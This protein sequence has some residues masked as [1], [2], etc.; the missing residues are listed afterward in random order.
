MKKQIWVLLC[1]GMLATAMLGGCNKG[2]ENVDSADGALEVESLENVQGK[3]PTGDVWSVDPD[4]RLS[5]VDPEALMALGRPLA[6]GE[7]EKMETMGDLM[8]YWAD[9]SPED[10]VLTA[11]YWADPAARKITLEHIYPVF[12]KVGE[13]LEKN[14]DSVTLSSVLSDGYVTRLS[15]AY[16]EGTVFPE[17][18]GLRFTNPGDASSPAPGLSVGTE[19]LYAEGEG[20]TDIL[21]RS[22]LPV[23]QIANHS[24]LPF[25]FDVDLALD[26]CMVETKTADLPPVDNT[27]TGFAPVQIQLSPLSLAITYAVIGPIP[28][29]QELR[30]VRLM[31]EGEV[32]FT[33]DGNPNFPGEGGTSYAGYQFIPAKVPLAAGGYDY[34]RL[35]TL[36]ITGSSETGWEIFSDLERIDGIWF[37][38][39][40]YPLE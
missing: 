20:Q 13:T 38:G 12:T 28:E 9:V 5:E 3:Q 29:G 23:A 2:T 40:T 7:G 22:A 15:F 25:P 24:D 34:R 32:Y 35:Y 8:D 36:L 30:P 27:E 14:G 37:E 10:P 26:G 1:V 4:M 6:T 39:T 19:N 33:Y 21:V 11:G 31:S 16:P 17:G 18:N